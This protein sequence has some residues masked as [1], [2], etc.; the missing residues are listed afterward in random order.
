MSNNK[1]QNAVG[2]LIEEAQEWGEYKKTMTNNKQ[3]TAVEKGHITKTGY[4][5]GTQIGSLNEFWSTINSDSIIYARHRVYPTA[6]FFSWQ[7]R[8]ISNWIERGWFFQ[9]SKTY[10]GGEQ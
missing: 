7:I 9:V 4:L 5:I 1:Q 6:F 3:Q 8:L 2:L 10:G